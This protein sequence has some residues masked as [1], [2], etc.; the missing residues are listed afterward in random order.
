M[1]EKFDGIASTEPA[2]RG[3][4]VLIIAG[5]I[6]TAL[7]VGRSFFIPIALAVLLSFVLNPFAQRLKRMR[8]GRVPSVLIAVMFAFGLIVGLG[9]VLARQV[10]ELAQDLPRYEQTLRE[11]VQAL[12][13]LP[14]TTDLLEKATTTLGK[15][16]EELDPATKPEASGNSALKPT[17]TSPY[18]S[19][20]IPVEIKLPTPRP[21]ESFQR[22]L[23]TALSPLA[24]GGVVILLVICI[25]LQREDLRDRVIRLIG[26]RDLERTTRAMDDAAGRLSR[27]YLA[28]TIANAC[29]G[30]ALAVGLFAIGVP[31]PVLWGIVAA[32]LR[33]V[34]SLGGLLAAAVPIALAAAVDPGWTMVVATVSLYLVAELLMG[35][36][37]EPRFRGR[38]TGLSPLAGILAL[39]F[40]TWAWGPIG[41]IVA[42]PLTVLLVVLGKHVDSLDFLE[43]LLGAAPA[44]TPDQIF[45]QRLLASDPSEAANQA[46]LQLKDRTIMAYGDE[47]ALPG[48]RLAQDDLTR[49]TLTAIRAARILNSLEQMIDFLP[50]PPDEPSQTDIAAAPDALQDHQSLNDREPA[51]PQA[52]R[53]DVLIIAGRTDL[54]QAAGL[55]LARVLLEHGQ[56]AT[57]ISATQATAARLR[58]SEEPVGVIALS[59]MDR[60]AALSHARF[61]ERRIRRYL[62]KVQ[63][64]L[65]IWDGAASPNGAVATSMQSA[66]GIFLAPT[67][68]LSKATA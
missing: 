37:V 53:P 20:P 22:F 7:T 68:D 16:G 14:V 40:W 63:I 24:T 4:Q 35:Q 45:Y 50:E 33:F 66:C 52:H 46:E 18:G 47:I 23:I 61:L 8:L 30:T 26:A 27:F 28:Q 60:A 55:I 10:T 12:R 64:V 17:Q 44:L 67:P 56:P 15:L 13:G 32:V 2:S 25:L 9:M 19:A 36:V 42:T 58:S 54:D 62:P 51:T 65:C 5:A 31:N 34:P 21:F 6:V 3:V 41:L 38:S 57:T 11:K 49:G 43:V 29:Y 48:L 1:S 39:M 59:Y